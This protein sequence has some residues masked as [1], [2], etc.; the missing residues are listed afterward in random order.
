M[1]SEPP[2]EDSNVPERPDAANSQGAPGSGGSAEPPRPPPVLPELEAPSPAAT[3]SPQPTDDSG[4]FMLADWLAYLRNRFIMGGL[5]IVVVL[6]L[7]A[8]VLL[9]VGNGDGEPQRRLAADASTPESEATV[10]PPGGLTGHV[11]TTATMRN[12]PDLTYAILGTIP[13]GALVSVVGRNA[14]ETWLQVTYPPGSQLRGWVDI[15]FIEVTGDISRLAV[16][17]PGSGPSVPVPTS[18]FPVAPEPIVVPPTQPPTAAPTITQPPSP[19][20]TE[21]PQPTGTRTPPPTRTPRPTAAPQRTPTSPLL[22]TETP[23][24]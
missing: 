18:A 3:G 6:L 10:V 7:I 9:V 21:P 24:A 2:M 16:A 23:T 17:G 8:V 20:A 5:A 13:R 1:T 22:P 14:N 12:G 11:R 19:T 4:G 15:T